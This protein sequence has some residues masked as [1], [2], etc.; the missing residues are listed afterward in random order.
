MKLKRTI[1]IPGVPHRVDEDD[2]YE[3]MFIPKN[4]M[5][6]G[7]IWAMHMDPRRCPN[8]MAYDPERH[9]EK[10]GSLRSEGG[11]QSR[12]RSQ[13]VFIDCLNTYNL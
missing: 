2:W 11:I 4:S 9:L 8:P 5:V 12:E 10:D 3:G 1:K 6:I 13:L 7:N